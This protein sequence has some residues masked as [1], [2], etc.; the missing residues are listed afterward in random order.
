MS[1]LQTAAV[2]TIAAVTYLGLAVAVAVAVGLSIA[3]RNRR[4]RHAAK[5]DGPVAPVVSL[6]EHRQARLDVY[7]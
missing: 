5:A 2:V 4:E 7:L 1:G 6:D 3:E